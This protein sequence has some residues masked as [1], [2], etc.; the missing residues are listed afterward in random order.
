[1]FYLGTLIVNDMAASCYSSVVSHN[2]AH[3]ML[4]PL[5]WW[6]RFA[7]LFAVEQ[8]FEYVPDGGIHWLP[9]AMLQLTEKFLPNVLATPSL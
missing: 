8:P 6:Y 7:K 2:L 9:K 5:R 3:Q 4:A 1:M